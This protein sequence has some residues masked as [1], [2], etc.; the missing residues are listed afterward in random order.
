MLNFYVGE[1]FLV[2]VKT[3]TIPAQ[4]ALIDYTDYETSGTTRY[5][6][7]DVV[8]EM[9]EQPAVGASSTTAGKPQRASIRIR[10]EI[11]EE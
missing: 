1:D 5:I 8:W 10:V 2:A 7:Q 9:V 4:G 11:A 6:V 3:N